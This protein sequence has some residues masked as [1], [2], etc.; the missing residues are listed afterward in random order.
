M[1]S[2][3]TPLS[4]AEQLLRT[5]ATSPDIWQTNAILPRELI[6]SMRCSKVYLGRSFENKLRSRYPSMKLERFMKE[7]G[8]H[9]GGH[10]SGRG[11]GC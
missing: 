2:F 6:A 5:K 4:L 1:D 8:G 10:G 11:S 9:E 3:S 7:S